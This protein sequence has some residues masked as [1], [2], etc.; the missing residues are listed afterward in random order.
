MPSRAADSCKFC[1]K[2][3]E[4]VPNPLVKNPGPNDLLHRR[5]PK[6][7]ECRPCF[8]FIK[9]DS[10]YK[11]MSSADIVDH[12]KESSENQQTYN[13]KQASWCESQLNGAQRKRRSKQGG[14]VINM[15]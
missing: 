9:D 3:F 13:S 11:D 8:R 6:S 14:V 4:K 12:L 10:Q 7:N 15:I 2:E 1:K 5:M